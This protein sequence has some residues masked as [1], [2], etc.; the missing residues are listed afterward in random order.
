MKFITSRII[1]PNKVRS[2]MEIIEEAEAK[3]AKE[4]EQTT[5]KT[6]ATEPKT[7]K[8]AQKKVEAKVKPEAKAEK[9]PVEKE[10]K[11]VKAS[12]KE[13]EAKTVEASKEKYAGK[14]GVVWKKLKSQAALSPEDRS[15]L[16]EYFKRYYPA[17]YAEA[18]IAQY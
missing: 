17:D 18:L 11:T 2:L 6:A 1:S 12:A 10:E 5:V 15:F 3:A 14:L 8:T 16:L 13:F 9:A 4:Q 7:K